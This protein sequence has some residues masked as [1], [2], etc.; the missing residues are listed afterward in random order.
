MRK[1]TP[2]TYARRANTVEFI[3]YNEF[4]KSLKPL[5]VVSEASGD[6]V[7]FY[8]DDANAPG[9]EPRVIVFGAAD[10]DSDPKDARVIEKSSDALPALMDSI[11]HKEHLTDVALCPAHQWGPIVDLIA[12][13]LATDEHW[14]DIDAEAALHV[15][16]RNPLVLDSPDLRLVEKIANSVLEGGE[17]GSHDFSVMAMATPLLMTLEQRGRLVVWC[18]NPAMADVIASLA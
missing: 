18:G 16:T 2:V 9:L 3:D 5:G 12:F 15:R 8:L 1:G 7:R 6:A 17:P 10:A 11:I 14:N 4:L 13:E